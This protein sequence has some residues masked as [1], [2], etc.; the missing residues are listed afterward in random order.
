M[1]ALTSVLWGFGSSSALK[2]FLLIKEM[3]ETHHQAREEGTLNVAPN[4]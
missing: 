4:Y 3:L 1:E 2:Y